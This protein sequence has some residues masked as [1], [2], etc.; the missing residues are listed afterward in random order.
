[1]CALICLLVEVP[2]SFE[3]A[4]PALRRQQETAGEVSLETRHRSVQ[5]EEGASRRA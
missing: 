5:G 2:E 3:A 1:M 4:D